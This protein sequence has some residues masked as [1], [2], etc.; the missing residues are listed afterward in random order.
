MS[1]L[2]LLELAPRQTWDH[3]PI[4]DPRGREIADRHYSRQSVGAKG[5][6]GPGERFA[7]LH[8]DGAGGRALWAVCRSLDPVGVMQWR[9][10]IFRN[11]S[12]TRSSSLIAAALLQT[13]LVW[14]RRY[15]EIPPEDLTTEI[16][17]EATADRRSKSAPPGICYRHAG[18]DF[19]RHVPKG[20]GRSEKVVLRAPRFI[21][22]LMAL[23][24]WQRQETP[25]LDSTASAHAC[26][27]TSTRT[28]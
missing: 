24:R 18:W 14:Q 26:S 12:S 10:S 21:F 19:V 5:Y 15:R 25:C 22:I 23:I 2:S 16:D 17:I 8:D 7:F 4:E 11:E 1:Q 6:V 20:H 27:K 9:N 28:S 3:I 13:Y